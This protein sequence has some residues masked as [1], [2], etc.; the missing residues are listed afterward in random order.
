MAVIMKDLTKIEETVLLAIFRLGDNAF[1]VTIKKQIKG[2]TKR[3]YLYSTLYTSLE[4]LVRKGYIDK[5]YGD[6][7]PFRGGKR[8][9]FFNVTDEGLSALKNALMK[10]KAIWNGISEES[11]SS[12]KS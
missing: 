1:G 8:K 2:V 12:R 9:L 6:S 10:Q 4:Q 11:L 3:D 5:R 7:Q